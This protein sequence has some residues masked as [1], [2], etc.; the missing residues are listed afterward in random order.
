MGPPCCVN[1]AGVIEHVG[2][3]DDERLGNCLLSL[4]EEQ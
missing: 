1:G 4:L 2:V 3:Y